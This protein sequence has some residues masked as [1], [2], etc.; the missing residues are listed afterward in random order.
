MKKMSLTRHEGYEQKLN[1]NRVEE[2]KLHAKTPLAIGDGVA[3]SI[4][5]TDWQ[6]QEL[7]RSHQEY[8]EADEDYGCKPV[9]KNPTRAN[10]V[11]PTQ[12]DSN[13]HEFVA[14]KTDQIPQRAQ[15]GAIKKVK[16]NLENENVNQ[17]ASQSLRSQVAEDLGVKIT[18]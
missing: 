10:N 4:V 2:Q 6:D 11:L 15:R 1:H 14:T 7:Q 17:R 3:L 5:E 8:R 12:Q 18:L 13:D 9:E 16:T